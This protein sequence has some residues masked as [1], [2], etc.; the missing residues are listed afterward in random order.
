M[1]VNLS[2]SLPKLGAANLERQQKAGPF[3]CQE[4][5]N[6]SKGA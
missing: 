5:T 4:R 1:R 6:V 2:A 3:E